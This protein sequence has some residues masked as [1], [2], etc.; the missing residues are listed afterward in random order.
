MLLI[1]WLSLKK[2]SIHGTSKSANATGIPLRPRSLTILNPEYLT[3]KKW[4]Y[5]KND[6][7]DAATIQRTADII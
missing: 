7:I 4:V 3:P 5:D 6:D 1:A 2:D